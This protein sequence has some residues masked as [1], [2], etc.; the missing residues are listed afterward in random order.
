M[1]SKQEKK[2][3]VQELKAESKAY[4][5]VAVASIASLPSRNFGAVKKKIRGQADIVF[6]RHTLLKMA[7]EEARPETKELLSFLG[8]GGVLV[9]TKLPAFKLYKLFKQNKSKAAAKPGQI[10]PYDIIVPAGETSLAPG[11]VLTEL[12]QAKIDARI[13]G[14]K[15]VIVKDTVVAKKGDAISDQAA[16]ILSKLGVTPMENGIDV[17]AVWEN[18]LLYKQD[19]LDVDEFALV[20]SLK[21]A[22]ASAVNLAVFAGIMNGTTAQI[23]IAKA[24]RQAN[25][26]QK[27]VDSKQ[28]P[29][30]KPAEATTAAEAPVAEQAPSA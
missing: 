1:I 27:L 30:E 6:A 2:K 15:V 22:H 17:K 14:T 4:P 12:K 10:A 7:L 21:Q 23:I 8:N 11:P 18:G 26:L 25:A 13:Q 28:A 24:A 5:V 20:E 29:A 9:F 3:L 16:K 19:V